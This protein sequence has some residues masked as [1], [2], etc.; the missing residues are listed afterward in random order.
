MFPTPKAGLI[1]SMNW[2]S[3]QFDSNWVFYHSLFNGVFLCN[4]PVHA[5]MYSC[6]FLLNLNTY[7]LKLLVFAGNRFLHTTRHAQIAISQRLERGEWA[8]QRGLYNEGPLGCLF[9]RHENSKRHCKS[10]DD[11][12]HTNNIANTQFILSEQPHLRAL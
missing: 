2:G 10:M 5:V 1:T 11:E 12:G 3:F 9:G 6:D 8:L 4:F 7:H